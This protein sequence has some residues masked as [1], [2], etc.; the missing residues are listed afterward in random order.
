MEL[1][2]N[3]LND[4]E[5]ED[6]CCLYWIKTSEMSRIESEGYVGLYY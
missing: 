1:S 2:I 3:V 5:Y 6:E 4:F